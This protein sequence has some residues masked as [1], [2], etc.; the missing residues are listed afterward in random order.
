MLSSLWSVGRSTVRSSTAFLRCRMFHA[1]NVDHMP[2]PEDP[3]KRREALDRY[4]AARKLKRLED[5]IESKNRNRIY[6]ERFYHKKP[7]NAQKVIERNKTPEV[8]AQEKK[9]R[10]TL[11]Y[12]QASSLRHFILRRPEIRKHL[13]WKSHTPVVYDTKRKHECAS[14]HCNPYLGY[15][16]WWKRHDE[17]DHNPDHSTD[18][19]DCHACFASDWR[20]A[21]P[22]GYEDFAFGQGKHFHLR[23]ETGSATT[24]SNSKEKGQ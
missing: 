13:T 24:A 22:V 10:Q 7:E 11:A 20:R 4:A 23:D 6:Q 12:R 15:R 5:P 14:C 8:K 2:L 19:Y 21:L 17:S 1:C 3:V 16:V 18:I 9:R